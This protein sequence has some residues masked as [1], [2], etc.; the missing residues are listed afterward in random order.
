MAGIGRNVRDWNTPPPRLWRRP[1]AGRRVR[2]CPNARSKNRLRDET[3]GRSGGSVAGPDLWHGRCKVLRRCLSLRMR[4]SYQTK[5]TACRRG[6]APPPGGTPLRADLPRSAR[7]FLF[8]GWFRPVR[9]TPSG[10]VSLGSGGGASNAKVRRR[11]EKEFQTTALL[12]AT[13]R[14]PVLLGGAR[15]ESRRPLYVLSPWPSEAGCGHHRPL[16]Q[17]LPHGLTRL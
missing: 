3:P 17:G 1:L 13:E 5:S 7:F 12:E 11:G 8:M 14:R 4:C 9:A 2:L 15:A 10:L 16:L 6:G